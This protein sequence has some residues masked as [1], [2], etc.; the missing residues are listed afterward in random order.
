MI[1]YWH[2]VICVPFVSCLS[3]TKCIVALKVGV[4]G[5]KYYH[6]VPRRAL[7]IHFFRHFCCKMCQS[8]KEAHSELSEKPNRQNFCRGQCGH[9]IIWLFQIWRLRHL[10]LPLYTTSYAVQSPFLVT[11]IL[12]VNCLSFA[13]VM[14]PYQHSVLLSL[15]SVVMQV[16]YRNYR[17]TR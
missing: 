2:D 8:P 13:E 1:G 5:W 3:A 11:A 7:P 17:V 14:I 6:H 12:L 4:W 16:K 10:V 15:N 9:E